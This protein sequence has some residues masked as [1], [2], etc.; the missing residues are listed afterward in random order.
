MSTPEDSLVQRNRIQ[1]DVARINRSLKALC[2]Y[3]PKGISRQILA[4]V[5]PKPP[6]IVMCLVLLGM[7]FPYLPLWKTTWPV[8]PAGPKRLQSKQFV[9]PWLPCV[10]PNF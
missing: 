9:K 3:I 7:N 4:Q 8:S 5:L 2:N 10:L 6:S 1:T